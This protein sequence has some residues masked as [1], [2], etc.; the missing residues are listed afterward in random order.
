VV[1]D[2]RILDLEQ[3]KLNKAP[4]VQ[5]DHRDFGQGTGGV[6]EDAIYGITYQS[7]CINVPQYLGFLF[8]TA[9]KLGVLAIKRDVD[10]TH[11]LEGV[12]TDAKNLLLA[13]DTSIKEEDIVALI[14]CTGLSAAKFLPESEAAKLYPVRGQTILVKGSA[15]MARTFTQYHNFSDGSSELVYV[16]P[17]PGSGTTILGGCKQSG[18]WDAE[19]D[20]ELSARIMERIQRWGL[21]EELRTGEGGGFEVLEE[22][23]GFRPARK[24]GPRVEV[25][26]GGKVRGVWVVHSYGHAGAGYQNSIGSAEKVVKLVGGL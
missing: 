6:P 23:V 21:A 19:V 24:G 9:A 18:N 16:I 5:S 25:Q 3:E 1:K 17:R 4:T 12:V 15:S 14:N 22:S 8:A 13:N 11:G 10:A 20:R 7:I 2:F 26:D